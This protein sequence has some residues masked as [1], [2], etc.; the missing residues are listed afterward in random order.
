MDPNGSKWIR[1]ALH[2][3]WFEIGIAPLP[4]HPMMPL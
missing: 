3:A 4:L 1:M 2:G